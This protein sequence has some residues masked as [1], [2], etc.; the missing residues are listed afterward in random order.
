M[1]IS[2]DTESSATSMTPSDM[3]ILEKLTDGALSMQTLRVQIAVFF[4]SATFVALGIAF[5]QKNAALIMLTGLFL[6]VFIPV[7][8]AVRSM[9]ARALL[10]AI[11]LLLKND[12]SKQDKYLPL[13]FTFGGP[14]PMLTH[15]ILNEREFSKREKMMWL[16]PY[17]APSPVGFYL[18]LVGG[19]TLC[20]F[21][22]LLIWFGGWS[23][24]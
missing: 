8:A 6:L 20:I 3:V 14:R 7:D 11:E 19:I 13:A 22:Y 5:G 17:M 12:P 4:G 21:G 1:T 16:Y 18:P 10:A 23:I 24:V 15:R 9:A 2:T